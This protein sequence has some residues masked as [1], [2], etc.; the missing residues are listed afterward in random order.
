TFQNLQGTFEKEIGKRIPFTIAFKRNEAVE[1]DGCIQSWRCYLPRD[2]GQA[3][4][5][6][7]AT[8]CSA[9]RRSCKG[10]RNFAERHV[11]PTELE[12]QSNHAGM[13]PIPPATPVVDGNHF[14]HP[15][16]DC[17]P[18]GIL[19]LQAHSASVTARQVLQ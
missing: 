15:A 6:I 11:L 19:C 18:Y 7:H 16:G 4:H 2:P 1:P 8:V 12:E 10:E 5:F 9:I 3:S 17:H 13:G 14:Q